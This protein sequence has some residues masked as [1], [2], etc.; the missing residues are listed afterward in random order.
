MSVKSGSCG[1]L[2]GHGLGLIDGVSWVRAWCNPRH[3]I[4]VKN[5]EL[6]TKL[7]HIARSHTICSKVRGYNLVVV[8]V[9]ANATC[10]MFLI[11]ERLCVGYKVTPG[12]RNL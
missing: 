8:V 5:C 10:L 12:S 7:A 3:Y 1:R 9:V 11:G 2:T 4:E 6:V